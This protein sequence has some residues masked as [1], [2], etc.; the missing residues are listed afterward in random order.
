MIKNIICNILFVLQ[1]MFYVYLLI[2]SSDF[3][4]Y[5]LVVII[6]MS[7]VESIIIIISTTCVVISEMLS[8]YKQSKSNGIIDFIIQSRCINKNE[9]EDAE[10]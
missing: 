10:Q 2:L 3:I 1:F 7:L 6:A 4:N 8:L 5:L 9:K